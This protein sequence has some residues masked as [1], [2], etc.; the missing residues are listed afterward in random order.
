MDEE[1]KALIDKFAKDNNMEFNPHAKTMLKD[2]ATL[3]GYRKQ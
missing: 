3:L 2:F 1:L